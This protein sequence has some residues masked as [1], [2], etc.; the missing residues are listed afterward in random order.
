MSFSTNFTGK[1]G[2]SFVDFGPYRD[3]SM[4]S[5]EDY[6]ELKVEKNFFYA[7]TPQGI[8]FG[9]K[10][11]RKEFALEE[12][13]AVITTG[14]SVSL[15]P[16]SLSK[17]FFKHLLDGVDAHVHNGVFYSDCVDQIADLFFMVEEHWIQI[18][19]RDILTDISE[20]QDN[21]I[22]M[23]NFIPSV[24][25]FWV[26]G[27]TIYKDYYVYHNPEAG[28]MGWVPTVARLKEPLKKAARPTKFMQ[29]EP[30]DYLYIGTRFL[31][32]Q[33]SAY[34]AVAAAMFVFTTSFGGVAFLNRGSINSNKIK[35]AKPIK[36]IILNSN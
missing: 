33:I 32:A 9:E 15:V 35:K 11:D 29:E 31:I 18:A 23:V 3:L 12:L 30:T 1:D 26:L 16:S 13:G 2:E 4:S 19:G 14:I 6:V 17:L 8:R 21:S 25:D 24:D 34:A 10:S 20:A 22:C 5:F 36:V 27:N 7:I 28:I